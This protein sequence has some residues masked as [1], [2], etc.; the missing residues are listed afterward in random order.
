MRL[1]F[2]SKKSCSIV[3]AGLLMLVTNGASAAQPGGYL[4]FSLGSADDEI[5]DES[6]TGYKLLGGFTANENLGIEIA[7][8]DLGSYPA[9]DPIFGPVVLDQY[10]VAFNG[11]GYLPVG[12][13]LD[14]FGKL[15]LFAWTVDV[16]FAT[17]DG[18]DLT[19]GFGASLRMDSR[20]SI[21][22]EWERFTDISGGDVDLLSAGIAYHF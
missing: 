1:S 2:V 10:G 16:G 21:R 6:D 7:F 11:V 20:L 13:Y 5:L 12:N 9:F 14:L 18:M 15:G 17:D 22:A 8:V 3:F 4:G 19:Y